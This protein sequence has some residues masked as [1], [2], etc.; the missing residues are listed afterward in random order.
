[1]YSTAGVAGTLAVPLD[2]RKIHQL[3]SDKACEGALPASNVVSTFSGRMQQWGMSTAPSATSPTT[4]FAE[5]R[6][7][8]R[9]RILYMR[10]SKYHL[11]IE[12]GRFSLLS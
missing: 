1:M 12:G 10:Q 11:C 3:H 8:S 2:P 7:A 5:G 9:Q 4:S 6:V